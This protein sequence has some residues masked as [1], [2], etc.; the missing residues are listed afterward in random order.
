VSQVTR[1][2]RTTRLVLAGNTVSMVGAELVLPFLLIY[3][4]RMQRLASGPRRGL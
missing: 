2:P 4:L 1:L 3:L